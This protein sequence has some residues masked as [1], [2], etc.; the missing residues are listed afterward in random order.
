MKKMENAGS[1]LTT[2]QDET[3]GIKVLN[4]NTKKDASQL[5]DAERW[6]TRNN[7]KS[8]NLGAVIDCDTIQAYNDN[9]LRYGS[10]GRTL[11]KIIE[12]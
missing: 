3:S 7:H 5:I 1:Q 8:G 2:N 11:T 12:A 4:C 6:C 10:I 9:A